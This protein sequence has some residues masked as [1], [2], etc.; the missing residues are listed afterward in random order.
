MRIDEI[1]DGP[2]MGTQLFKAMD[3]PTQK[4]LRD[5]SSWKQEIKRA[6]QRDQSHK[7]RAKIAA[8]NDMIKVGQYV[9]PVA[10]LEQWIDSENDEIMYKTALKNKTAFQGG[11]DNDKSVISQNKSWQNLVRNIWQE[12]A[13]RM[14][15][16]LRDT[17]PALLTTHLA[18]AV[19]ILWRPHRIKQHVDLQGRR[20]SPQMAHPEIELPLD[21]AYLHVVHK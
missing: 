13:A 7:Y 12:A 6:K 1:V 3:I 14:Y 15:P 9:V 8:S 10:E 2:K 17:F 5:V 19:N 11:P 20:Y 4:L 16:S 18:R 21:H